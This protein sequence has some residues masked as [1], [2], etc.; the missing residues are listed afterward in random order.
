MSET[1]VAPSEAL[2]ALF[3]DW[4]KAEEASENQAWDLLQPIEEAFAR[5]DDLAAQLAEADQA[6]AAAREDAERRIQAA[7]EHRQKLEHD[8]KL[9]RDRVTDLE[10]SLQQRT[11]DLLEAQNDNN[12]LAAQLQAIDSQPPAPPA[13]DQPLNGGEGEPTPDEA[14]KSADPDQDLTGVAARFAKLRRPGS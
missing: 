3:E 6:E 13:S 10:E 5:L 11:E 4:S 8:L 9:A 1:C 7:E 12:E 14:E 2:S